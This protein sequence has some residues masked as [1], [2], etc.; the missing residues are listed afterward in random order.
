M[1]RANKQLAQYEQIR[2][3]RVLEREFT[4][5]DGELTPTMK[6]RRMNVIENFKTLIAQM[7]AG[8]GP[9]DN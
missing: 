5:D 2:K 8:G 6:V 3:F 7:Y 4:I 1:Q 9:A